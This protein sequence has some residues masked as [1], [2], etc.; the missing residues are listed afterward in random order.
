MISVSALVPRLYR[1]ET[2]KDGESEVEKRKMKNEK[3]TSLADVDR[4]RTREI[5]SEKQTASGKR[6]SFQSG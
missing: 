4:S 2:E 3:Y 5:S 1:R 6:R